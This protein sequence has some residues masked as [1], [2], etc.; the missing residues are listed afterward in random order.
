[1]TKF[2]EYHSPEKAILKEDF[3]SIPM[4]DTYIANI[5]EGKLHG[6]YKEWDKEGNLIKDT[7]YID[8]VEVV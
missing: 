3:K 2:V 5:I 7:T 8:G 6:E 4:M 1:M